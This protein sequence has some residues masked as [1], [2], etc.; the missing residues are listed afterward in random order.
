MRASRA[1]LDYHFNKNTKTLKNHYVKLDALVWSL[2]FF[3]KVPR[4]SNAVYVMAEY[5]K[6][7]YDYIQTMSMQEFLDAD[8]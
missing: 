2:I 1:H 8:I 4:Y 5:L 3:E 7:N 6:A